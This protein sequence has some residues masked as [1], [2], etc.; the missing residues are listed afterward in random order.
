M[1]NHKGLLMSVIVVAVVTNCIWLG[2]R[3]SAHK[4]SDLLGAPALTPTPTCVPPPSG[5]VS[6]WPGDGNPNDIRGSNNGTLQGGATFAPGEVGQAFSLDGIDDRIDVADNPNLNPGT[7]S[8]TVDAWVFKTRL[9]DETA[10]APVVT[11]H[12]FDFGNGYSLKAGDVGTNE[13]E[14]VVDDVT[15]SP[16]FPGN[17]VEVS[18]GVNISL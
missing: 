16:G 13:I 17:R 11:K 4:I 15:A 1:S 14:A 2:W 10:I 9:Q 12:V 3:V 7:G 8:F 6:W 5:M 18:T